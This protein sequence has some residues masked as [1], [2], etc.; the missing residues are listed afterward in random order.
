VIV[1]PN[2][3]LNL[4]LH[5]VSKRDDGFHN[6]E[7]VFFPFNFKDALEIIKSPD[8]EPDFSFT[9]SG[10]SISG[11]KKDNLCYKAYALVKNNH[12]HIPAIQMHLHKTI[13]MGA[14]MGGGSADAAFT[15]KLL[16][17]LFDLKMPLN[18]IHEMA[19]VLGSD[20][21]FFIKN[22][23]CFASGRGE[24]LEE[25]ILDLS[26]YKI[27]VIHPGIHINTAWAFSQIK[28]ATPVKSIK[29]IISQPISTW[30]S[31]L[32]NDFEE[33][34]FKKHPELNV[35]KNALY[36]SGAVY[37]SMTGSGSAI[38]GIFNRELKIDKGQFPEYYTIKESICH[39]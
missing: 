31:A 26:D 21:P 4:G 6:L 35:I 7:T 38:F 11:E 12:P 37:A 32:I 17:Q 27:L 28:P 29:E 15:I 22:K 33:P 34:V 8:N 30:K 24:I 5:I 1:F 13:P 23:T 10:L 19:A 16:N 14:G 25:I 39:F 3:K 2:C 18:E 9:S 36:A 20:C